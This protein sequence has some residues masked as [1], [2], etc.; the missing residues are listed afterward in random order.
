MHHQLSH[1]WYYQSHNTA[2]AHTNTHIHIESTANEIETSASCTFRLILQCVFGARCRRF[3]PV[4]NLNC[5]GGYFIHFRSSQFLSFCLVR[6]TF[7]PRS[8]ILD[9]KQAQTVDTTLFKQNHIFFLL[10]S[11][12][13]SS[14]PFVIVAEPHLLLLFCHILHC[15]VWS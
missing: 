12:C 10:L 9:A 1:T 11:V 13:S 3:A 7:I 5:F 15:T 4:R 2:Y 8:F 14:Y 6:N